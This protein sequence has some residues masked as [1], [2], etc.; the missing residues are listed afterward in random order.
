MKNTSTNDPAL[1]P[2]STLANSSV[3]NHNEPATETVFVNDECGDTMWDAVLQQ[4]DK[5]LP[6]KQGSEHSAS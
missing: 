3:N 2:V 6:L 4:E 5:A 1:K